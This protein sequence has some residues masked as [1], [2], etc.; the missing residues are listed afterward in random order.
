MAKSFHYSA[1]S[2]SGIRLSILETYSSVALADAADIA[3]RVILTEHMITSLL[4][5]SSRPSKW[6]S[7]TLMLFPIFS[8]VTSMSRCSGITV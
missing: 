7:P 3:A 5:A 1:M 6:R 4:V 2:L 8:A